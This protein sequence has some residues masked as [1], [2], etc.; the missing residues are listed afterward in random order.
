MADIFISYQRSDEP[1][2]ELLVQIFQEAGLCV[3]RDNELPTASRWEKV[4]EKELVEAKVILVCWSQSAI[5]SEWVSREAKYALDNKK[6]IPVS[7]DGSIPPEPFLPYQATSLKNWHGGLNWP[8]LKKILKAI[9]SELGITKNSVGDSVEAY[10]DHF[11]L[12]RLRSMMFY[13]FASCTFSYSLLM[14]IASQQ[15]GFRLA[16]VLLIDSRPV[17]GSVIALVL[18]SIL[19]ITTGRYLHLFATNYRDEHWV[20]R[21]PALGFDMLDPKK[22]IVIYHAILKLFWGIVFPA[23]SLIHFGRIVIT[24][25]IVAPRG[26]DVTDGIDYWNYIPTLSEILA[27]TFRIGDGIKNAP[28]GVTFVPFYET[29]IIIFLVIFAWMMSVLAIREVMR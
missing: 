4:I 19:L 27:D 24:H 14:W 21:V 10:I 7:F 20:K 11:S 18:V 26:R 5:K 6:Y 1:K 3:W 15:P 2:V 17:E 25:G 8:N 9:F 22:P 16:Q 12:Q 13:V 29:Y 23:L 28:N